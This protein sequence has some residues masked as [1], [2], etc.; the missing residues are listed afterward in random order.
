MTFGNYIYQDTSAE[1]RKAAINQL[2]ETSNKLEAGHQKALEV[3]SELSRSIYTMPLNENEEP[4][5]QELFSI[6][7]NTIKEKV[8]YGNMYYALTDLVKLQ[9]DLFSRKDVIA[10]LR[11]QESYK[12]EMDEIDKR[13]DI[14]ET[15]KDFYKEKNP[16]NREEII[17]ED[18]NIRG[19]KDW[20][21]GYT[22]S[23]HVNGL[24][25]F[26]RSVKR[27]GIDTIGYGNVKYYDA[28]MNEVNPKNGG[29]ISKIELYDVYSGSH[30]EL[31]YEDILLSYLGLYQND[32]TIVS[33]VKDEMEFAIW[34]KERGDNTTDY[35]VYKLN[36]DGT[37]S[38]NK[39][40]LLEYLIWKF[41]KS[42]LASAYKEILNKHNPEFIKKGGFGRNTVEDYIN[43]LRKGNYDGPLAIGEENSNNG[44]NANAED[45]SPGIG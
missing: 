45:F 35:G 12:K 40:T 21:Q 18:G 3:E 7:D 23:T 26:D 27:T 39:R 19:Y 37:L 33:S 24:D 20:Q 14:L 8:Q 31:Y 44:Q 28:N 5:R 17:D 10:A 43:H 9:K 16:Y 38:N 22:V 29:N 4:L 1:S 2:I 42:G 34:N 36:P 11:N 13:T 41:E 30:K 15:M 25:W 6:L 32:P